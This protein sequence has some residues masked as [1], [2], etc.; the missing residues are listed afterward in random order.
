VRERPGAAR[1]SDAASASSATPCAAACAA[2]K[3]FAAKQVNAKVKTGYAITVR[4]TKGKKRAPAAAAAAAGDDDDDEAAAG[5]ALTVNP[6]S[7]LE[8]VARVH[9]LIDASGS[10]EEVFDARLVQVNAATNT[11]KFYSLQVLRSGAAGGPAADEAEE[12][13]VVLHWGRTGLAGQNRVEG[14]WGV[15]ACVCRT[16]NQSA[17]HW[18]ARLS[19]PRPPSQFDSHAASAA[20]T[21]P[22]A[23][24]ARMA[25]LRASLS[26][27]TAT[28]ESP[29]TRAT[30][31]SASASVSRV[32]MAPAAGAPSGTTKRVMVLPMKVSRA[33]VSAPATAEI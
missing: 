11:D 8:G 23:G 4:T 32:T 30:A 26:T 33:A 13:W 29:F 21:R 14:P 12:W 15:C 31:T 20:P 16:V 10:P 19:S 5:G 24:A 3:A 7:G 25:A 2:A 22:L 17:S 27:P 28:V 18:S 1:P 9:Y 6:V